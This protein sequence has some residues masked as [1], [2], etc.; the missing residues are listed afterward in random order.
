MQTFCLFVF[1]FVLR[2]DFFG[3]YAIVLDEMV[4]DFRQTINMRRHEWP[5]EFV[6][7]FLDEKKNKL[8]LIGC[9]C[10]KYNGDNSWRERERA[11]LCTTTI[12]LYLITITTGILSC[13]L[14]CTVYTHTLCITFDISIV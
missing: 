7:F 4:E 10:C 5:S 2:P 3:F 8:M 11:T 13:I 12:K 14:H 9:Q 1:S 6:I